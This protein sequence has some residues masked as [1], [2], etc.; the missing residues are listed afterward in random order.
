VL[1]LPPDSLIVVVCIMDQELAYIGLNSHL[2]V[3]YDFASKR[4]VYSFETYRQE[5]VIHIETIS[6]LLNDYLLVVTR[7]SCVVYFV[8]EYSLERIAAY[9]LNAIKS[10]KFQT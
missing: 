4:V 3:V 1:N 10:E 7:T 9:T 8:K 6:T 5:D 2:I